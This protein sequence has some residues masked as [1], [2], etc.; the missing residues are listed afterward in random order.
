MG[1]VGYLLQC[2]D[3]TNIPIH[4]CEYLHAF[5]TFT[6]VRQIFLANENI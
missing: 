4:K 2:N 1:S 5:L 3:V 6:N